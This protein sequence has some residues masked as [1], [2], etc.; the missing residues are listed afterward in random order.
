MVYGKDYVCLRFDHH[1]GAVEG[2]GGVFN[3]LLFVTPLL[4]NFGCV[5]EGV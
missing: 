5:V 4:Y 1:A 2:C 3:C